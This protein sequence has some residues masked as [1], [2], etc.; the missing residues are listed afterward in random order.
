MNDLLKII[1]KTA[2]DIRELK[3]VRDI[4]ESMCEEAQVTLNTIVLELM[5]KEQEFSSLTNKLLEKDTNNE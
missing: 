2:N 5:K 1:E 4:A 3:A